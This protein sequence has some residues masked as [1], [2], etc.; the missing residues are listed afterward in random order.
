MNLAVKI[1][2]LHLKNPVMGASGTFGFGREYADFLDVNEIGAIVT[3]GVTPLPR[4]G[5]P[6]VR[7]A[8]TPSGML[9]CIGLENPGVE[10][11]INE[12]LP[13]IKKYDTAVIVNISAGTVEEYAKMAYLLDIDG[14]DA[15]EV[16]I[17]CPNVKE[18][19]IVFGTDP[20]AAAA[21]T[22]AVKTHTSKTVIVKLS[23]NVTD[24][25][26]MAKA[27]E[28]AGADAISM[29]N[30]LTGMVIDINT[31]KPLLGNITGGLSG[32]AVKPIAVRMVWQVAKAVNIPIIGMGGITCAEDAVEFMLAGASAVAVGAYNFVEPSALKNIA[33]GIGEYMQ[34]HGIEDVN[35]LIGG[36]KI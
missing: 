7:I 31:R 10:V 34:K 3:K 16:N 32:P 12:I 5:N 4:S 23:P 24:I 11:F 28:E 18:G 15:L 36:L 9:N 13:E 21:V 14:V 26:A 30:T 1:G 35:E 27:V 6:G 8:E 33:D 17:S 20:K 2:N 29:I 25:V 22:H 19:G